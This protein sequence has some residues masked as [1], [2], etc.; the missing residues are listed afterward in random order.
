M[1]QY[2]PVFLIFFGAI[3]GSPLL[4]SVSLPDSAASLYQQKQYREAG[5]IYSQLLEAH[6]RD[7]TYSYYKGMCLYYLNE[8]VN[9]AYTLLKLASTRNVPSDVYLGLG[10]TCMRLYR[11]DEALEA[12]GRYE[13]FGK[14]PPG[15]LTDAQ[16]LKEMTMDARRRTTRVRPVRILAIDSVA[17]DS[18]PIVIRRQWPGIQWA[19]RADE[20]LTDYEHERFDLHKVMYYSGTAGARVFFSGAGERK[21]GDD[22]WYSSLMANGNWVTPKHGG[23]IINTPYHEGFAWFDDGTSVLYYTSQGHSSIGGFDVFT[24]RYD[25]ARDTWSL[26]V[27]MDFPVNSTDNEMALF[28][29]PDTSMVLVTDRGCPAGTVLLVHLAIKGPAVEKALRTPADLW[30]LSRLKSVPA[31]DSLP[32]PQSSETPVPVTHPATLTDAPGHGLSEEYRGVLARAMQKQ[33]EADSLKQQLRSLEQ[34]AKK[35]TDPQKRNALLSKAKTVEGLM[36]KATEMAAGMFA[37]ARTLETQ[38]SLVAPAG[39]SGTETLMTPVSGVTEP[40]R[41]PDAP[42]NEFTIHGQSVY[43]ADRPIPTTPPSPSGLVYRIQLGAF[44]NAVE[45]DRFGGLSP[46]DCEYVESSAVTRYYTGF[47]YDYTAASDALAQTR[48]LG[49]SGAFLVAFFNGKPIPVKRAKEI[50]EGR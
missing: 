14:T 19:I 27:P 32:V 48:A 36:N 17:A 47:F 18:L 15:E 7:F 31:A 12:F 13:Q 21:Q 34:S 1:Q 44:R 37:Q 5:I 10:Q 49:Q 33:I 24:S 35:E 26:P 40:R 29:L 28:P 50:E 41:E 23:L 38:L 20:L 2:L 22:I 16:R 30:Q 9:E 11:F 6:P 25:K 39:Q 43:G 45:P 46:I 3:V 42:Q 8:Q 4:G